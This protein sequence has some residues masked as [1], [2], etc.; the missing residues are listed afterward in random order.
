MYIPSRFWLS[1]VHYLEWS[2]CKKI[3]CNFCSSGQKF[4]L[5]KN[6]ILLHDHFEGCIDI[7]NPKRLNF[8]PKGRSPEGWQNWVTRDWQ[9]QCIPRNDRAIVFLHGL[10]NK[11]KILSLIEGFK[12]SDFKI[13]EFFVKPHQFDEF[14]LA[15][16]FGK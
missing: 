16:I 7:A 14:F 10:L 2:G 15:L 3:P 9:Y 4:E 13:S 5:E 12:A 8:H 11:H 6:I 1:N